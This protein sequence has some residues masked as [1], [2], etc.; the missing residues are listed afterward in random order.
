MNAINGIFGT[1]LIAF[2]L[3]LSASGATFVVNTTSDTADAIAG[4]GSCA[5]AGSN[6]SLRAAISEANALAGPDMIALGAFT[7]TLALVANEENLN[8][9]GDWDIRSDITIGGVSQAA[10]ILQ[11]PG[12]SFNFERVLDVNSGASLTLSNVTV[13]NGCLSSVAPGVGAGIFNAGSLTLNSA[14]VRDN[15]V[16]N[17]EGPAAGGGI[18]NAGSSLTITDTTITNNTVTNGMFGASS[19]AGIASFSSGPVIITNSSVSGNHAD[20]ANVLGWGGGMYAGHMVNLTITNSH[21]DNNSAGGPGGGSAGAGLFIL[22]DTNN[23]SAFATISKSTFNSNTSSG[24]NSNGVGLTIMTSSQQFGR[25]SVKMD[26]TTINGNSGSGAGGGIRVFPADGSIDLDVKNTTISN[27]VSGS[28]GGGVDLSTMG[29]TFGS[30]ISAL[31]TNTTISG[32]SATEGGA[33]SVRAQPGAITLDLDYCTLTNNT[34]SVHGGGLSQSSSGFIYLLRS[35]AAGNNA[36]EGA[37]LYA[38]AI[39]SLDY[40]HIGNPAGFTMTGNTAHNTNG[41][42][43]LGPLQNNGGPTLTHLPDAG[44]PL[45]DSIP[46]GQ[47]TCSPALFNALIYG[48]QRGFGRPFGAGCDKGAVERGASL[49][50]GPW[51]LSGTVKTTNDIPIRNVAVNIS[52]GNLPVPV[53]VFTGNLGTYQFTNLTGNDY[54]V[55]VTAKRYHFNESQ[56]VISLGSNITNADFIANAP[57]TREVFVLEP[58]SVKGKK[59]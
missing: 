12:C 11:S 22:G 30:E 21:F 53:T 5:D 23:P 17:F 47:R 59:F 28:S 58:A 18:Y 56:Q 49:A 2:V 46:I 7:Y 14:A 39:G 36:P 16:Q 48:D 9:G 51:T 15:K 13:R 4:D 40:N 19:G 38:T 43:M 35:V 44:S 54:T 32:N 25:L 31:F 24:A 20:S 45:L 26:Q 33:I 6:C 29:G 41:D 34:A 50:A 27:N 37:D 3:T 55:T 1:G 8:A 42:P 10:T 57:F 52:G